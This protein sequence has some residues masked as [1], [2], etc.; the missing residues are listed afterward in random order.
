MKKIS[1]IIPVYNTEKYIERCLDSV[2]QQE[3]KN[4]EI[5]V[6]N[7]GST[8]K[9]EEKINKYINQITYIKKENGGLSDARNV[10]IEKATGE[11]IMFID[12]D[13]YIEEGL[14]D[15]LKPYIDQ[16][17]EMIKYK[18][19]KVTE[20]GK[21]IQIMDGPVFETTKGEEAFSKMCFTDQLMETA[22]IY[23]YKTELLRKNQFKFPKGLYHEDFGLIP[24]IIVKAATF[25]STNICGYNY[26]QSPNSIT[27][28][29]DYEKTKRKVYDLLT[30]YDKIIEQIEK[31]DIKQ[32]T[33]QDVR[34]FCTNAIL[35]RL[36]ELKEEDKKEIIKE[37]RKRKMQKN[38]IVKN[39]KQLLKR[40]LLEIS[41]PAYLKLR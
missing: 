1:I 19:R 39:P 32:T 10:G 9:S 18:S 20:E 3:Y 36:N 40:I 14:L 25:V 27:R 33:K 6:I 28:N 37:I 12:S 7:D 8:D 26:V 16:E 13:D 24:L 41:I 34:I 30:H 23:L 2:I 15:K 38:I 21:E 17:I 31:Y 29:E 5:I 22:C 11:Y 4:K 35:L